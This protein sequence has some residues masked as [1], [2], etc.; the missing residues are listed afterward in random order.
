MRRNITVIA[1]TLSTIGSAFALG[2][3]CNKKALVGDYE[4]NK[5]KGYLP[6]T[7][8]IKSSTQSDRFK[9][10]LDSYHS[11]K[12]NDDGSNTTQAIFAGDLHFKQ[13]FA[14]YASTEENDNCQLLFSFRSSFVEVIHFGE[15]P[16]I[17]HNASPD[18]IYKRVRMKTR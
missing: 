13:C 5:G 8:T 6:S 10:E 11:S 16:F 2:N 15:C 3:E 12:P 1:L 9:F 7:L 17:G 14:L 18:G 4:K